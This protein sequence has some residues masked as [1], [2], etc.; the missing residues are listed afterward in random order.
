MHRPPFI[1][2]RVAALVRRCHRSQSTRAVCAESAALLLAVLPLWLL[3]SAAALALGLAALA[4]RTAAVLV[5][6]AAVALVLCVTACVEHLP[7]ALRCPRRK[8][9][10]AASADATTATT[11][12]PAAGPSSSDAAADTAADASSSSSDDARPVPQAVSPWGPAY[13]WPPKMNT[14]KK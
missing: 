1:I 2:A 14:P 7:V 3:L 5:A 8:P 13:G 11:T 6:G 4:V 9:P 12:G 10:P